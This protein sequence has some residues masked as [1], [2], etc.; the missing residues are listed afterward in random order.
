MDIVGL[1]DGDDAAL[2][3]ATEDGRVALVVDGQLVDVAVLVLDDADHARADVR[4]ADDLDDNALAAVVG[5][6]AEVA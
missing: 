6:D 4:G 2:G 1:L 3:G 5:L